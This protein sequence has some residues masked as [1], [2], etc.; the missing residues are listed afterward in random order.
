MSRT[1]PKETELGRTGFRLEAAVERFRRRLTVEFAVMIVAATG[2]LLA[3]KF[4]G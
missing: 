1:K 3:A 2:V 4:F